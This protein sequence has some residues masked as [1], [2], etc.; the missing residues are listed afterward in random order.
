M[1]SVFITG[2]NRGIGAALVRSFAQLQDHYIMFT[3]RSHAAEARLLIEELGQPE[4]IHALQLDLNDEASIKIALEQALSWQ[5]R[6]DIVIHNAAATADNAFFFM[7]L[8]DW[9]SVIQLSLN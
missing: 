2:G 7:E 5:A 6:Y 9:N 8:S 4:R 3:Y 1:K